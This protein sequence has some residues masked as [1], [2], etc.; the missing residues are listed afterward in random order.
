MNWQTTE[1][2]G[3]WQ[4]GQ[5]EGLHVSFWGSCAHVRGRLRATPACCSDLPLTAS[6]GAPPDTLSQSHEIQKLN[7][8]WR[9]WRDGCVLLAS[10][11]LTPLLA[12]TLRNPLSAPLQMPLV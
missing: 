9:I 2:V 6:L 11:T 4:Y 3:E 10:R 5:Y 8:G 1:E 12:L 7:P